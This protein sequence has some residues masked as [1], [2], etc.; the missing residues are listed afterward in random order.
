MTIELNKPHVRPRSEIS[1]QDCWDISP[2]YLN[3]EAWKTD[4][5]SFGLKTDG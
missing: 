2:L 5:D 1:P 4:L 3:R